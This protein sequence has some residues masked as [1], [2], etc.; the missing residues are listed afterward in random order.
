[1][2]EIQTVNRSSN[3]SSDNEEHTSG[4]QANPGPG[5]QINQL[6]RSFSY[7]EMKTRHLWN[8]NIMNIFTLVILAQAINFHNVC[9]SYSGLICQ[10]GFVLPGY[11][12]NVWITACKKSFRHHCSMDT[13]WSLTS[14]PSFPRSW[15]IPIRPGGGGWILV[16]KV[17][18]QY[19][20]S[21][22]RTRN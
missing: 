14:C 7:W 2:I 15:Y 10:A 17:S 12:G 13:K 18:F 1:M 5:E 20:K 6:L 4:L 11:T 9:F 22:V 19:Y 3:S 8:H 21:Q 16:K